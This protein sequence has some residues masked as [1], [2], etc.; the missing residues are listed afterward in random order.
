MPLIPFVFSYE[1]SFLRT[2]SITAGVGKSANTDPDRV[3]LSSQTSPFV[4]QLRYGLATLRT[5]PMYIRNN[6]DLAGSPLS[7]LGVSPGQLDLKHPQPALS[8]DFRAVTDSS[9]CYGPVPLSYLYLI[10]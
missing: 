2:V 7:S 8:I 1:R 4:T 6:A 3:L 5:G 9:P 10:S